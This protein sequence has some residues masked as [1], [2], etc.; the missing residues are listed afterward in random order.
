MKRR[1]FL[2][3]SAA[4]AAGAALAPQMLGGMP[5]YAKSPVG[6]LGAQAE[7]ND[8]ILIIIQLFGGNDGLNTVIPAED[9]NYYKLR[10]EISVP[11]DKAKR[12]ANSSFYL[13]PALVDNIYGNGFMGLLDTGRLAVVQGIGYEN[14]NLSHFR[15]TDIWLSGFNNSDPN[16]RLT[17][18]WVGRYFANRL[19]NFPTEIPDHPLCVQIGGTLSL[20]FQ[21][22]KG[23]MGIALTDPDAFFKLGQGLSPDEQL[24]DDKTA[25]ADEFNYIRTIALQSDKYSQVVKTAFDKGKNTLDYSQGFAQQMKLIARLI[26]GGL[27]SKVFMCSMGGFDT[28]VQQQDISL[29]G[30]HPSLLNALSSGISQFI[31]DALQQGFANRVVGLTVSEFGRR[32]SENG[33][34]GTDHGAASVQFVF[35]TR[36]NGGVF[37]NN[38]NLAELNSNNDVKY[39]YDYRKVYADVLQTWFGA[40]KE[41]TRS[42]LNDPALVALPVL[43]S[44]VLGVED[45]PDFPAQELLIT[46]NP[47]SG[48]I[49]ISFELAK[50]C[51]IEISMTDILGKTTEVLFNGILEIGLQRIPMELTSPSGSYICHVKIGGRYLLG[52]IIIER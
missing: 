44:P 27:R 24:I 41:E 40:S 5:V 19:T 51:E 23:D 37:G 10:P 47:T 14:P 36:V 6:I 50:Q 22:V 46:P 11:K 30:N 35:G 16:V 17:D 12:Y 32:P 7:E 52:N 48:K 26:S 8:A 29:G 25:Y 20:A 3:S 31:G 45:M 9:D 38:P 2:Q 18:G 39:Q 15:S 33:S 4:I 13:H 1:N 42:L 21:S 43:Q 28:H 34:R 49:E